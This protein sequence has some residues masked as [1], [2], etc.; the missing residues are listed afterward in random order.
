MLGGFMRLAKAVLTPK[1][2]AKSVYL[3]CSQFFCDEAS[4]AVH[5]S[6]V[7][8]ETYT[9]AEPTAVDS[10]A[11][12]KHLAWDSNTNGPLAFAPMCNEEG[13]TEGRIDRHADDDDMFAAEDQSS[14]PVAVVHRLP[15]GS[16]R[17]IWI[18]RLQRPWLDFP[19]GMKDREDF[20]EMI[21]FASEPPAP[22]LSGKEKELYA[23]VLADP[24][25]L[26]I[27]EVLRDAWMLRGDPRG[28]F[29]A[30]STMTNLTDELRARAAELVLEHGRAWLGPLQAVVPQSGALFGPGPFARKLVV[31]AADAKAFKKVATVPEWATVEA[32]EFANQSYRQVVPA[33]KNLRAVGPLSAKELE[34]LTKGTWLVEDLEV[35]A[36]SQKD[37]AAVAKL[38]LPL[39]CLRL[40]IKEAT[41]AGRLATAAWWSELRRLELWL[42]GT[43]G[44]AA[45]AIVRAFEQLASAIPA[46]CELAVG[47][48]SA[49]QRGG[50]MLAG[51]AKER[52]LELLRPND[53]LGMG[54][55]LAKATKLKLP[56]TWEPE[57]DD[58]FTFGLGASASTKELGP[59][60]A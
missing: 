23:Q 33:M 38:Q 4:D 49:Y 51:T 19:D 48:L 30:L 26:G 1:S 10:G 8:S 55:Q 17:P 58:W 5:D 16:L 29:S 47:K 7:T 39:T 56:T 59:S 41:A 20:G 2:G 9:L 40:R 27:R 28:E 32:I 12:W 60:P 44:D 3:T 57:P 54:A 18:A 13:W 31:Y 36:A 45:D 34:P 42:P 25:D 11:S 15:D 14:S 21:E 43:T 22:L 46:R 6:L 35:E 24:A 52:R 50:W 37:L 53:E